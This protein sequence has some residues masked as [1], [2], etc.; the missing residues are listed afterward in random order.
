MRKIIVSEMISVDGFFAG[1]NGE[2]DWHNVDAEFNEYAIEMLKS[3]DT[4]MFGRITYDLMASY[5][6]AEPALKDDPI[7]AGYMNSLA[8]IVF[9]K[10]QTSLPWNNTT[11]RN[12]IVAEEIMNMKQQP[13]K[14]IAI[15]GS[16]TIVTALTKLGLIDEYRLTVN[17]VVLGK[18]K[19][20]FAGIE[21]RLNFNLLDSKAY[22]NQNVTLWYGPKG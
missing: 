9:S 8:K 4:L 13:G 3:L 12:E 20:L 16:G 14:D 7:V 21:K 22:K 2:I 17:P 10:T 19:P 6:P 11:V 5:W 1:P 18:G 15:F